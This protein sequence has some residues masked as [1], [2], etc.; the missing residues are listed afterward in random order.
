M[1]GG[2]EN[3]PPEDAPGPC[4]IKNVVYSVTRVCCKR[5]ND[6]LGDGAGGV[7]ADMSPRRPLIVGVMICSFELFPSPPPHSH[8][9]HR[10]GDPQDEGFA[11]YLGVS[12]SYAEGGI[13]GPD[14]TKKRAG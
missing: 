2:A 5:C 14:D 8:N 9:C 11:E 3:G 10:R 12:V 1:W 13:Q 6:S 7:A 4:C